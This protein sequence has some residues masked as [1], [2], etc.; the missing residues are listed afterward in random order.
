MQLL[1]LGISLG[2]PYIAA[3]LNEKQADVHYIALY[4]IVIEKEINVRMHEEVSELIC[5]FISVL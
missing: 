4:C 3:H 2:P 5:R 1:G